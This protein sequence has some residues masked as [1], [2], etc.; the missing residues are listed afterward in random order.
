MIGGV[1]LV[2]AQ[3]LRIPMMAPIALIT[4]ATAS[5]PAAIVVASNIQRI[6]LVVQWVDANDRDPGTMT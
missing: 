1:F 3:A 6:P 4:A 5:L 2:L